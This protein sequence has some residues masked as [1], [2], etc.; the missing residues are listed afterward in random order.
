M[1]AGTVEV[2]NRSQSG[3]SS[4]TES[5]SGIWERINLVRSKP[6]SISGEEKW[7]GVRGSMKASGERRGG[8]L[9]GGSA[10]LGL[11]GTAA[12][13]PMK[14]TLGDGGRGRP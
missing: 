14:S 12:G 11:G 6:W 1:G 2:E 4:P 5:V 8:V 13:G 7:P 10:G 9:I 3:S